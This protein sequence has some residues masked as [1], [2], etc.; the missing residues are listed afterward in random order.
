MRVVT[1]WPPFECGRKVG[2]DVE[3]WLPDS[4]G[5]N[6]TTEETSIPSG[7][8]PQEPVLSAARGGEC[9]DR[10]PCR[11]ALWHPDPDAGPDT[12]SLRS[13]LRDDR[14][15]AVPPVLLPE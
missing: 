4:C 12:R 6:G 7:V 15:T 14:A 11:D 9:R 1:C 5:R 8:I 2:P 13:L 10:S 3:R